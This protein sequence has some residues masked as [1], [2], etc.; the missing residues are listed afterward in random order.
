[1]P[2]DARARRLG[3]LAGSLASWFRDRNAPEEVKLAIPYAEL[4][5]ACTGDSIDPRAALDL[6]EVYGATG[7]RDR[8]RDMS[9]EY[10]AKLFAGKLDAYRTAERSH[11]YR[12][13]YDF[14]MAL[15]AI[16]GYLEQWTPSG[17]W[18]PASAIFQLEH[19]LSTAELINRDLPPDSKER[20][21]VP[22]SAIQLLARAYDKTGQ[23]DRSVK[24]LMDEANSRLSS[25]NPRL[26]IDLIRQPDR[27]PVDV[28]RASPGLRAD[29]EKLE[30][31]V[32]TLPRQGSGNF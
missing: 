5:L 11:D 1:M 17:G 2:D 10:V 15:G 28:S 25:P 26:A 20:V 30:A 22:V 13:I 8:I 21:V 12:S 4:A 29:W 9:D 23:P 18:Q 24:L 19:V 31:K 14:H 6:A 7:Q 32:A 3:R 27:K 16:Y